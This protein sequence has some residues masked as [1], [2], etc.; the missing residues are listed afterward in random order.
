M[1]CNGDYAFF[2]NPAGCGADLFAWVEVTVGAG[3]NGLKQPP[4]FS[5]QWSPKAVTTGEGSTSMGFYN[6]LK[7]DAPYLKF[8]ADN[9]SMSD[10]YHQA[11]MGGTGANH[12]MMGIGD[13]IFFSDPKGNPAV[14]P[15]NQL[16]CKGTPN[17][18]VV[19]RNRKPQSCSWHQ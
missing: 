5:T 18:G 6:V 2:W 14:P 1:D 4:N 3:T 10:N 19:N 16:V 7:G 8:L 9:Y 12:I 11:A 15:Q 17:A 13:A